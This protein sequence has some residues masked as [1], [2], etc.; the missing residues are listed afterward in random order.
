MLMAPQ[1]VTVPTDTPRPLAPSGEESFTENHGN[2]RPGGRSS[3]GG[4]DFF[5]S[6]GMEVK[7]NKGLS[8]LPEPLQV[9]Q[10]YMFADIPSHLLST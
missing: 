6:L 2:P 9:R 3:D 4:I 1:A 8:K 5:S 7:R 10:K